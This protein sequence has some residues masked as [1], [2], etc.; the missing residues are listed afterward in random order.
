MRKPDCNESQECCG[1][2]YELI[3]TKIMNLIQTKIRNHKFEIAVEGEGKFYIYQELEKED[4]PFSLNYLIRGG[5]IWQIQKGAITYSTEPTQEMLEELLPDYVVGRII[6]GDYTEERWKKYNG[7]HPCHVREF[8]EARCHQLEKGKF[9]YRRIKIIKD[10]TYELPKFLKENTPKT[11]KV[12]Y[13]FLDH[14]YMTCNDTGVSLVDLIL[15]PLDYKDWV[16]QCLGGG[17]GLGRY[18]WWH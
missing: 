10:E 14:V 5:L 7:P 2:T 9:R 17:D 8:R 6:L 3:G 11:N 15:S 18:R 13:Q 12:F 1:D 4:V 16:K